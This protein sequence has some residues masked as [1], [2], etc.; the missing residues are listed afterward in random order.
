MLLTNYHTHCTF[1]DGADDPETMVR[2][3]ADA[4]FAAIGFSSH[5]PVHFETRWSMNPARLEEYLSTVTM[6]KKCYAP[7][8][9]VYCGLEIDYF[10]DHANLPFLSGFLSRNE[11]DYCIGS[12]HFISDQMGTMRFPVDLSP[13]SFA[14]GVKQ[15]YRGD[16]RAA[17]ERYYELVALMATTLRPTV[18]GHFDLIKKFNRQTAWFDEEALWYKAAVGRALDAAVAVGAIVEINTSIVYR[19]LGDEVYPG[20]AILQEC[21]RRDLAVTISADAHAAAH[22]TSAVDVARN[23]ALAAGYT[24]IRVLL[25]GTWQDIALFSTPATKATP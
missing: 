13:E 9:E 4:G 23:S 19:G 12:V 8:I 14:Q 17:V 20:S 3:A 15:Y 21:R 6:L 7:T 10:A 25:H 24:H 5:A 16:F 18:I 1:C 11:I 22:L 2:A